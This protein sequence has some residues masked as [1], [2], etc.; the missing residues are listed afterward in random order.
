MDLLRSLILLVLPLA[1]LAFHT[2]APDSVCDTM[3]P[4]H[5]FSA[6]SGESPYRALMQKTE[7]AVGETVDIILTAPTSGPPFKGFL[8]EVH[9]RNGDKPV[10]TFNPSSDDQAQGVACG[11]NANS[12]MTH[13]DLNLKTQVKLQWTPPGD[14]QYVLV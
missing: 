3:T 6:Q 1:T 14:G 9:P 4:G 12:A 13:K 7:V 10:G 11:G 5:P 2:G 8:V